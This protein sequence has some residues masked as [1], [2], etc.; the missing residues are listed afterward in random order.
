[1]W[2][3]FTAYSDIEK[4]LKAITRFC[5]SQKH[6]DLVARAFLNKCKAQG[7]DA[8]FVAQE[9][10]ESNIVSSYEQ[11]KFDVDSLTSYLMANP[12]TYGRWN[13]HGCNGLHEFI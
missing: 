1:M 12:C 11:M 9:F 2:V 13:D 7:R 8:D 5:E 3:L 4:R 10:C 6:A